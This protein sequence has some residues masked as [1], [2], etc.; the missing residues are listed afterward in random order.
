MLPVVKVVGT[1]PVVIVNG[2]EKR[3]R[4]DPIYLL[5]RADGYAPGRVKMMSIELDLTQ[6]AIVANIEGDA[7]TAPLFGTSYFQAKV[8]AN[9]TFKGGFA[10]VVV[11]Y[12]ALVEGVPTLRSQVIVHD[13]PDLIAGQET[14]IKFSAA[15]AGMRRDLRYFLQLF[16]SSG[17]EILTTNMEPAWIYFGIRD[18]LKLDDALKRYLQA[19]AGESLPAQPVVVAKPI[20]DEGVEPPSA[21][22]AEALL[23]VKADGTVESVELTGMERGRAGQNIVDTLGGW[24][25]FPKLEAG[26]PVPTKVKVPLQF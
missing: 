9:Q 20:F 1:N 8:R 19:H 13:I 17:R 7:S 16:D 21:P 10:T 2:K 26:E 24:L 25:F 5:Q 14:W 18:R 15:L 11:Y 4:R 22:D 3:I 6:M 23:D 12:P